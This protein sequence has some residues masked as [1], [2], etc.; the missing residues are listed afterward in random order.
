MTASP[1]VTHLEQQWYPECDLGQ[2]VWK[3]LKQE[4]NQ[5][6]TRANS[7]LIKVRGCQS[8][9]FLWGGLRGN[10]EIKFQFVSSPCLLANR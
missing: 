4:K 2:E 5:E 7:L 8:S 6:E 9:T 10:L 3:R 1:N